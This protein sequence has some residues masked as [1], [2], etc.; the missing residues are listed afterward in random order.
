MN[1]E[2][3]WFHNIKLLFKNYQNVFPRLGMTYPEKINSLVRMS[4]LIGLV[5]SIV[6]YNHLFLYIPVILMLLTYVLFLFREQELNTYLQNN[7]IETQM[8]NGKLTAKSGKDILNNMPR[9]SK[10][11]LHNN[12]DLL[13]KFE[14]YLDDIEY[15]QPNTENPFMNAMPFDSRTRTPATNTISNPIKSAEIEVSFDQ[16]TFRDVN[17]VFDKNNGKRQF[18]TMPWTTYP[19]DQGGFAN[20]LYKTPPT[21]KEGNGAQ[22][23]AN[24]YIPLNRNLITPGVGSSP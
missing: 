4:L 11:L 9:N 5:L 17:D 8:I 20:W 6:Y 7:N 18:F 23:I 22:C 14:N 10:S 15:V 12:K 1:N 2:Q 21:C 16:G 3:Y 13:N 24:Y 19:N